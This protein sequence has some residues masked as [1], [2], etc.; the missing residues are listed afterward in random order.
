MEENKNKNN[1]HQEH[2]SSY[3]EHFG[4]W[5]ALILLTLMTVLVSVFGADLRT[6]SVAT[7]MIIATVKVLAVG[8]YFMHLKY[9]PK[10][11]R[12]LIIIVMALFVFFLVMVI[13]DY[14][15]R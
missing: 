15:T 13:L 14:L 3:K 5:S 10:I 7:A 9:E 4:T 11:Y 1:E 8:Y 6:L 2:I 12:T